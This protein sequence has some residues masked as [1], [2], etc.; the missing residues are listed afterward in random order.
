[1]PTAPPS[2]QQSLRSDMMGPRSRW[3]CMAWLQ[4]GRVRAGLGLATLARSKLCMKCCCTCCRKCPLGRAPLLP[5][6]WVVGTYAC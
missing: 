4:T 2:R 1:M 6:P 3:C 5:G